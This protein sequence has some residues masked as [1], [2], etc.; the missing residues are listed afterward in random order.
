MISKE[1]MRD[2]MSD[3]LDMVWTNVDLENTTSMTEEI[4]ENINII[5]TMTIDEFVTNNGFLS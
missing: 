2:L 4:T 5:V 1:T 3:L